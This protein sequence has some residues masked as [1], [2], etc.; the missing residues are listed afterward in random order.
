[1]ALVTPIPNQVAKEGVAF[2][3]TFPVGTFSGSGL[4]YTAFINRKDTG[5]KLPPWLSFNGATRTLSGTPTHWR[6]LE[7]LQIVIAA[8]EA[9]VKSYC[10]FILTVGAADNT[11]RPVWRSGNIPDHVLTAGNVGAFNPATV[12]PGDWVTIGTDITANVVP[13]GTLSKIQAI[14]SAGGFLVWLF[15]N[16]NGLSAHQTNRIDFDLIQAGETLALIGSQGNLKAL[17]THGRLWRGVRGKEIYVTNF[18]EPVTLTS[19]NYQ[20]V[21]NV[22]AIRFARSSETNQDMHIRVIGQPNNHIP[23]VN[24]CGITL[25]EG[26]AWQ[27]DGPQG[28]IEAA[29][30]NVLAGS[31]GF[32]W[33]PNTTI[34]GGDRRPS[35]NINGWD[36]NQKYLQIHDCVAFGGS[37]EIIYLGGGGWDGVKVQVKHYNT[38]GS[39]KMITYN[40]QQVH[41]YHNIQRFNSTHEYVRIEWND[42]Q[43]S[44]WDSI[45]TRCVIREQFIMYNF[46]R[47]VAKSS[48]VNTVQGEGIIMD[49][50]TGVCAYNYI[51]KAYF[52]PLR[53]GV[54]GQDAIHHNVCVDAGQENWGNPNLN[55]PQAGTS[56][57]AGNR[58]LVFWDMPQLHIQNYPTWDPLQTYPIDNFVTQTKVKFNGKSYRSMQ[59]GNLGKNPETNPTWW[60]DTREWVSHVARPDLTIDD[61]FFKLFNNT[62]VNSKYTTLNIQVAHPVA[63]RHVKNN[64]FINCVSTTAFSGTGS[65]NSNN[66]AKIGVTLASYFTDPANNDFRLDAGVDAIGAG[67]AL[68]DLISDPAFFPDGFKDFSGGNH[69]SPP[70]IGAFEYGAAV[71]DHY[72]FTYNGQATGGGAPTPSPISINAGPDINMNLPTNFVDITAVKSVADRVLNQIQ[73]SQISGPSS[74]TLLND[75]TLTVTITNLNLGVYVFRI[76]TEDEF[77]QQSSDDV[78]VTVSPVGLVGVTTFQWYVADD[79]AGTNK[80]AIPGA[81]KKQYN[82]VAYVGQNKWF[83]RGIRLVAKTGILIGVEQLS[84]WVNVS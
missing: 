46:V 9:G 19:R 1:M 27:V 65:D 80:T 36:M 55:A 79:N 25:L 52:A 2:S 28:Y 21:Q 82:P 73:W 71:G 42:F 66:L 40:G 5:R 26:I 68:G 20:N 57:Y 18:N 32:H 67:V 48:D 12:T 51:E 84:P 24:V 3:Y 54:I 47:E 62:F 72:A 75:D 7:C 49:G 33:K 8:D 29:F 43:E 70:A 76:V 22:S 31:I 30:V 56:V 81:N 61:V 44:G 37:K 78:T 83:A 69:A 16:D 34:N 15:S 77:G 13:S 45:Q 11:A 63:Q 41:E 35:E 60:E 23:F 53:M 59:P 6:H 39:P 58:G 50:G 17:N 38:D 14:R 4:T 74:S 64:L 10:I